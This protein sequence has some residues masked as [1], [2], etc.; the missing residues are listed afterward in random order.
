MVLNNIS[1]DCVIFGFDGGNL[2]VLLWQS[3]LNLIKDFYQ[4]NEDW[5]QVKELFE[6]NPLNRDENVWGLIGSHVP[7]RANADDH[8]KFIVSSFTGLDEI[9][10]QQFK[11]FDKVDRVPFQ[12]VITIAFYALINPDYHAIKKMKVAKSVKWFNVKKLPEVIF[13]HNQIISEALCKLREQVKYHPIGF[14]LLSEK[15][16]LTQLQTLY[17]IIL[18]T[19]LDTRNF[20]KKILNMKLLVDTGEKQKNVAHR[21]AR[22]YEFDQSIYNNLVLEGLNFRI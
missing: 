19:K 9:F 2:N 3:E 4:Y 20:R 1:V 5:E 22:L 8:A 10:L 21:A 13:D 18:D 17:E 15:F 16:T 7:E 11:T 6:K 12:R 14:H